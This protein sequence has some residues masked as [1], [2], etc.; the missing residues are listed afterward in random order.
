MMNSRVVLVSEQ[1]YNPECDE[2]ILSLLAQ[3]YV[4]FCVVGVDCEVWENVIDELSIGD[5]SNPKFVTTTSHPD[6]TVED[7]VEFAKMLILDQKSGVDVIG[8]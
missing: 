7:V 6:E 4:L 3:D 8:I 2:L 5:G 1:K